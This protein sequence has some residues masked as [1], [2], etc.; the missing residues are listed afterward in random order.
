MCLW[1][2][3]TNE[4]MQ[5]FIPPG[6]LAREAEDDEVAPPLCSCARAHVQAR[7]HANR[8]VNGLSSKQSSLQGLATA[9][10][11]WLLSTGGWAS[12]GWACCQHIGGRISIG[13]SSGWNLINMS[14][15]KPKSFLL[16][17]PKTNEWI[18]V[19]NCGALCSFGLV[20]A[21]FVPVF[22]VWQQQFF[23]DVVPRNKESLYPPA[24]RLYLTWLTGL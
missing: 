4:G 3:F 16:Y 20:W 14:S 22:I 8:C 9:A 23:N 10:M 17:C 7:C 11:D 15:E 5:S 6:N 21:V 18:L 24:A 2:H 12:I 13:C 19:A 1:A